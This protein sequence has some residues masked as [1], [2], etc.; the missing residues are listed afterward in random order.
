MEEFTVMEEAPYGQLKR[1][2]LFDEGETIIAKIVDAQW[3]QG[4]FSPGVAVEFKT[5]FPQVGYS[6]RN[7]A[8]LSTAKKDGSHFVRSYGELDL[9]QRAALTDE[10][11]FLQDSVDPSAWLGRP[12]AFV[13]DQ[14]TYETE[15]GDER[16][17]NTIKEG[18]MR[19]PTEEE[20]ADLKERFKG[21]KI[22]AAQKQASEAKA[23]ASGAGEEVPEE[24]E[25]DLEQAPF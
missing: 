3:I 24:N 23:L 8:Y 11:F 7:T 6:I 21:S 1:R 10:E 17:T 12:V 18:T 25:E 4:K 15:E 22:L 20:L 16:K 13:V 19:K 2:M 9:I 5:V 14:L